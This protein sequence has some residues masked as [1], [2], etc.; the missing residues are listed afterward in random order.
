MPANWGKIAQGAKI[1]R[2]AGIIYLGNGDSKSLSDAKDKIAKYKLDG[3]M[4]GRALI[5][6][7]WLFDPEVDENSLSLK[8]KTD[9]M[10]EHAFLYEKLFDGIKNFR[11]MRK[12]FKAYIAGYPQIKELRMALMCTNNANE[13]KSIVK[14]H[15][16]KHGD[17]F[18]VDPTYFE[19]I[20]R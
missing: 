2:K 5:G 16:A 8:Q 13:A 7:P 17:S 6:N 14:K 15:L 3:V 20:H 1:A 4:V 19:A 11:I 12:H 9:V 10:L 18:M